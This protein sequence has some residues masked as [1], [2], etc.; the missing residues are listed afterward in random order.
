MLFIAALIALSGRV[1][2]A[3]GVSGPTAPRPL[4]PET[5]PEAAARGA[6]RPPGLEAPGP[7][8]RRASPCRRAFPLPLAPARSGGGAG[9]HAS[10]RRYMLSSGCV[11]GKTAAWSAGWRAAYTSFRRL[12]DLLD[13]GT[14][15]AGGGVC[16][17]GLDLK[18]AALFAGCKRLPLPSSERRGTP[19][20]PHT[21]P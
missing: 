5:R 10:S 19:L 21:N 17:S 2:T 1:H 7:Q 11:S 13:E 18:P 14:V 3:A 12:G 8:T 20:P 9:R 15:G 6:A 4:V 16:N